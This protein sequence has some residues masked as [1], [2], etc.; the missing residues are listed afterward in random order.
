MRTDTTHPDL[1]PGLRWK[2]H[3]SPPPN[4]IP[5]CKPVPR[6]CSGVCIHR[7]TKVL[8]H[9]PQALPSA[10]VDA[11]I[12]DGR[13]RSR[14]R[15]RQRLQ[16][17]VGRRL[18]IVRFVAR[19]AD[20][21]PCVNTL[22]RSAVAVC[23][24]RRERDRVVARQFAPVRRHADAEE[25][26][27]GVRLELATTA[28]RHVAGLGGRRRP[29]G[30]RRA[31]SPLLASPAPSSAP[32]ASGRGAPALLELVACVANRVLHAQRLRFLVDVRRSGCPGSGDRSAT[33]ARR[34]RPAS[35][36]S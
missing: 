4:L 15:L 19:D 26:A 1:C 36:S 7:P 23:A 3:S 27:F 25:I 12:P 2:G 22:C 17:L 32:A 28:A 18:Q 30:P 20:L 14:V 13:P 34:S 35:R 11:L 16:Q 21:T 33:A 6:A 9:R 5:S 8:Q 10:D 31:P 24:V 29:D